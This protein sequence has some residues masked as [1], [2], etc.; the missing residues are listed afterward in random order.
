M[1]Y[2]RGALGTS[3]STSAT[4]W[5][6][7][8]RQLVRLFALVLAVIA[9]SSPF[10]AAAQTGLAKDP[11]TPAA[12][13]EFPTIPEQMPD[14]SAFEGKTVVTVRAKI[15]GFIWPKPPVLQAPKTGSKFSTAVAREELL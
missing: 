7:S 2:P 15:D 14:V 3:A 13:A 10:T 4:G 5:N 12:A 1:T 11:S 6:S 8:R 9:A